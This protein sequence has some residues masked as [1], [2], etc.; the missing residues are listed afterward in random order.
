ML[1]FLYL[2]AEVGVFSLNW[3]DLGNLLYSVPRTDA[4]LANEALLNPTPTLEPLT[5][6]FSP[7]GRYLIV[8]TGFTRGSGPLAEETVRSR[9]I[10]SL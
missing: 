6:A 2:V 10:S 9:S 8:G 3:K 7:L 5:V 4:E 1:L